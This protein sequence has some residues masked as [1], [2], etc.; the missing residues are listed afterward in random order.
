MKKLWLIPFLLLILLPIT[1]HAEIRQT[2]NG[3][4]IAKESAFTYV[5]LPALPKQSETTDSAKKTAAKSEPIFSIYVKKTNFY[6]Q[7]KSRHRTL[8]KLDITSHT[9]KVD[10]L[11]NKHRPPIIE[12]TKNGTVHILKLSHINYT[13]HYFISCKLKDNNLAPL[14][15]AD[16]VQIVFSEITNGTN[17]KQEKDKTGKVVEVYTKQKLK[18]DSKLIEHRY[19]IPATIIAEWKDVLA[20]ELVPG[21]IADSLQ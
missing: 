10:L 21:T 19:T 14:Y 4:V 8:S 3:T 18:H 5:E 12:Y 11:F 1:A 2:E 15:D 7:P 6:N 16:K 9:E 17:K 13:N 20:T